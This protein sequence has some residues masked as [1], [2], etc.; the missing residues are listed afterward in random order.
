LP[1]AEGKGMASMFEAAGR[2]AQPPD[3]DEHRR[4]VPQS[5]TANIEAQPGAASAPPRAATLKRPTRRQ[6]KRQLTKDNRSKV[7]T[8]Q[9]P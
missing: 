6:Q 5:G 9:T 7:F 3:L 2:V 1:L 4:A 8:A